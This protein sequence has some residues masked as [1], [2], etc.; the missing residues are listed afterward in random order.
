MRDGTRTKKGRGF[1][2]PTVCQV[3]P[4][5]DGVAP[6]QIRF[7]ILSED[8]QRRGERCL[9]ARAELTRALCQPGQNVFRLYASRAFLFGYPF[10]EITHHAVGKLGCVS[11]LQFVLAQRA[12]N[13]PAHTP[14]VDAM[15]KAAS[16]PL[17]GGRTDSHL[18]C[19]RSAGLATALLE[20]P[21]V[22][23]FGL[24]LWP[25]NTQH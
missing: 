7:L 5:P 9:S 11:A 8:E 22:F 10:V 1:K 15:I 21:A 13:C 20:F 12:G 23:H 6:F 14:A 17:A 19:S 3:L 24:P 2:A 18:A 4:R 16:S 25:E